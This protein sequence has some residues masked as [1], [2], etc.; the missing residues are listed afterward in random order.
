MNKRSEKNKSPSE[1]SKS[2][3]ENGLKAVLPFDTS[4]GYQ[5]RMTHR[6]IQ[7]RLQNAI[8]PYGVTLGM[9]YFL[10]ALWDQD[11]LT[12]REL[13][14]RVGTM[15]PTTL[16][17]ISAMERSGFVT[18]QRNDLDKRKINIRLTPAGKKLEQRLLPLAIDVI[19]TAM[20]GFSKREAEMLTVLLQAIQANL[21]D[22]A[23]PFSQE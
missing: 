4:L 11:G 5:V 18:R 22:D 8:E 12:Q 10:R 2:S 16:T 14:N 17:A 13:S 9:W 21:S 19:N 6:A 20:S 1:T 15:E 3:V 23:E 7:R